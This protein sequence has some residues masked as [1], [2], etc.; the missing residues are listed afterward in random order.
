[1]PHQPL[2]II[3]CS[4]A[5]TLASYLKKLTTRAIRWIRDNWVLCL[6]LSLFLMSSF[7]FTNTTCAFRSTIGIPCPGCGLTRAFS[8]FL[9]GQ[10]REAFYYHPLFWLAPV[11]AV[12]WTILTIFF[13][14]Y[15]N[16]PLLRKFLYAAGFMFIAVYIARMFLYF[17]DRE[18]MVYHAKSFTGRLINWVGQ[19]F[20]FMTKST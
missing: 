17:P 20:R 12:G 19:L 5:S 10:M 6:F 16:H 8:A 2:K 13:P 7:I 9:L 15:K 3:Q 18:P 11:F 1:M 14:A 4:F